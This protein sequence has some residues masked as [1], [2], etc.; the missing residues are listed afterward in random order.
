MD[1]FA[2]GGIGSRDVG[3]EPVEDRRLV[4]VSRRFREVITASESPLSGSVPFLE[5]SPG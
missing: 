5:T 2:A 1:P 3:Y 4:P